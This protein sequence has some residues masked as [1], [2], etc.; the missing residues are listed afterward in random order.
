MAA[1]RVYK[2]EDGKVI[3]VQMDEKLTKDHENAVQGHDDPRVDGAAEHPLSPLLEPSP[4]DL[5]EEEAAKAAP[6]AEAKKE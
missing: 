4:N 2:D 1:K 3:E 5:A 6:K